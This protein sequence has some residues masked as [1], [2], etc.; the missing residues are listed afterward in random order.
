M[1]CVSCQPKP[2]MPASC[3]LT[4]VIFGWTA[5]TKWLMRLVIPSD[6]V[7]PSVL[8]VSLSTVQDNSVSMTCHNYIILHVWS[9]C[10][11]RLSFRTSSLIIWG[12]GRGVI[13]PQL[14]TWVRLVGNLS[15][16]PLCGLHSDGVKLFPYHL[17]DFPGR[18]AT[19][20]SWTLW[21]EAPDCITSDSQTFPGAFKIYLKL[22]IP[23]LLWSRGWALNASIHFHCRSWSLRLST[24]SGWKC[25]SSPFNIL[26]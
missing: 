23:D 25:I 8:S 14:H 20:T 7:Q 4:G 17:V 21:C 16:S 26:I 11:L 9:V 24:E 6:G 19:Q 18:S 22:K 15:D 12:S 10:F 3:E 2:L 5:R 1:L 13:N